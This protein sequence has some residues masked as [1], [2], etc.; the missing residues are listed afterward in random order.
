M[1]TPEQGLYILLAH[2][3]LVTQ[4]ADSPRINNLQSCIKQY[5]TALPETN[6][7]RYA[8]INNSH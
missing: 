3:Q 6:V 7:D 2:F 8:F 1:F 5:I 4:N